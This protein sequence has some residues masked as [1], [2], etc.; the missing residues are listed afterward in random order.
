MKTRSL[1]NL[2]GDLSSSWHW[3]NGDYEV[4]ITNNT[5]KYILYLIKQVV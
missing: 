5:L 1:K 2:M 4:I 3:G